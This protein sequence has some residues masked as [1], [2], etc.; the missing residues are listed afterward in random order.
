VPGVGRYLEPIEAFVGETL[1]WRGV[2]PLPLAT[3]G[4]RCFHLLDRRVA[5]LAEHD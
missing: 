3:E 4:R 2:L 1:Y 5:L